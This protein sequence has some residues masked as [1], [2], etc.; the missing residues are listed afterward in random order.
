MAERYGRRRTSIGGWAPASRRAILALVFMV[1]AL[2]TGAD[3]DAFAWSI[4]P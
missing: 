1:T 3:D 2:P 4:T